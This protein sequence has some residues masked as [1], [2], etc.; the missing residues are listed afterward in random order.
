MA[1]FR[2]EIG[3]KPTRNKTFQIFLVISIAGNR[4]RIKTS[5]AVNKKSD[6]NSKAKQN[7]WIR[8]SEPNALSW[9]QSLSKEIESA[10]KKTEEQRDSGQVS[11]KSVAI[12]LKAPEVATKKMTSFIKYARQRTEELH[13]AGQLANWKKYNGFCNKLE[14]FL[15]SIEKKDLTFEQITP[16]FI[17][18]FHS[19]LTKLPNEI[20]P[21]KVIHPNS[22][23]LII[24]IF[25]TLVKR[26]T[27]IES[28]IKLEDNPFKSIKIDEVP[29]TKEKLDL[30]E[31]QRIKELNLQEGSLIWHCRNYFLFSFYCAGIRAGDLIQLR[32]GNITSEERLVYTMGKNH[33]S[34]ELILVAQAKK[35]LSDYFKEEA[36]ATDYIFPM[37]DNSAPYSKAITQADK[38][39]LSLELKIK[40]RNQI[41]T[42]N[43]LINKYLKKIA[44]QARIEKNISL[45]IARHSFAKVAK[46]E[47]IDNYVLKGMLNH[48]SLKTTE[49]YMKDFD[50]TSADKAMTTIFQEGIT[51]TNEILAIL[52]KMNPEQLATILEQVK[53]G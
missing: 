8:P 39:T 52:K 16:S 33:K 46:Q 53:K 47:G 22:I 31:I 7:N 20:Q 48:S 28:L 32:W 14:T 40:L 2:F 17:A 42:Y 23:H 34:R 4:T 15:T 37:L 6:F 21:D 1:S 30:S 38:D 5:I 19:Y 27:E 36:K 25:K 45:H 26:A 51:P 12:E 43:A 24:R 10:R 49:I 13:Q 35:I 44:E 3:N 41:S 9:N 29:T 18:K 11:S 50:N